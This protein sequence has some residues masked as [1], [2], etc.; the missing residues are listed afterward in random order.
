L[1]NADVVLVYW[2]ERIREV[3]VKG[4]NVPTMRL[5]CLFLLE[6]GCLIYSPL[7]AAVTDYV[8]IVGEKTNNMA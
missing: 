3:R 7:F 1:K 8:T 6:I 2:S 4:E 5:G